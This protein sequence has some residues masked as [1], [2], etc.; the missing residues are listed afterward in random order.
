M[1]C[2]NYIR[3]EEFK[4]VIGLQRGIVS[5]SPFIEH[6]VYEFFRGHLAP[7]HVVVDALAL[8]GL[9]APKEQSIA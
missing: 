8:A 1:G 2:K 6:G 7:R 4:G 3:A 9:T 5:G